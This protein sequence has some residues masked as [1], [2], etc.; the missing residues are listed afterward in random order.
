MGKSTRFCFEAAAWTALL[1][2]PDGVV[3]LDKVFRQKDSQFLRI[4]NEMRRGIVTDET[5][6][7][8][9]SK[10]RE[11]QSGASLGGGNELVGGSGSI[12]RVEPTKLFATNNNVDE[13][14]IKMLRSLDD[15]IDGE[16]FQAHVG[17]FKCTIIYTIKSLIFLSFCPA[18]HDSV[19]SLRSLTHTS[20]Y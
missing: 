8:M 4:L 6:R 14:N 11:Y 1:S 9:S 16:E 13:Y 12:A 10:V 20:R 7:I 3:V 18:L 17:P 15:S 19:L 2:H 5:K